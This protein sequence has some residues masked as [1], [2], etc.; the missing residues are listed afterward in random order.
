RR[1]RAER[2]RAR[3]AATEVAIACAAGPSAFNRELD[4]R[5]RRILADALGCD[6]IYR[7]AAIRVLA[8]A[9]TDA[10]QPCSRGKRMNRAECLLVGEPADDRQLLLERFERLEDWR[11]FEICALFCRSPF[12]HDRAVRKIDESHARNRLGRGLR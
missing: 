2:D 12:V 1:G 7:D 11:Y 4:G 6:L 3:I 10:T 9:R 5:K 8:L